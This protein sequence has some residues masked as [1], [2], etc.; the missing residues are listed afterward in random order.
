MKTY[1]AVYLG[2]M[3]VAMLLNP[4]LIRLARRF[5]WFHSSDFSG[6]NSAYSP[7]S[8]VGPVPRLGGLVLVISMLLLVIPAFLYAVMRKNLIGIALQRLTDKQAIGFMTASLGV[9]LIGLAS[10]LFS[11]SW[12]WKR[13]G[14]LAAAVLVC[15][16]GTVI[17]NFHLG[18]WNAVDLNWLRWPVT[19]LWIIGVTVGVHL[20]DGL[21]GLAAGISGI[22]C[23][24]IAAVTIAYSDFVV[25]VIAVSMVGGL[26]GFLFKNFY[27]AKIQL[28]DS[29]RMFVGFTIATSTVMCYEKTRTFLGLV[30]P[31]LA[32]GIPI[33]N[34]LIAI[35][36]R[37][38]LERRPAFAA[39]RDH[40]HTKLTELG[41]NQRQVVLFLYAV[42]TLVATVGTTM[43]LQERTSI[44]G[45]IAIGILPFAVFMLSGALKVSEFW[46][47]FRRNY[48]LSKS[49]SHG[50]QILSDVGQRMEQIRSFNQWWELLCQTAEELNFISLTVSLERRDSTPNVLHWTRRDCNVLPEDTLSATL[51]VRQRRAG[52]V[53]HVKLETSSYDTAEV[54]GHRIMLF[55]RLLEEHCIDTLPRALRGQR[56]TDNLELITPLP[57]RAASQPSKMLTK[58]S[59]GKTLAGSMASAQSVVG[60][61]ESAGKR[62]IAV[63]HDFLYVYAGAERVLEQILAVYP[64]ADVFAL[65]DFLP[66]HQRG[67]LKGKIAKT[68]FLQKMPLAR[69]YHRAYLPLMPLAIEQLDVSEYDLVI[70]SSYLAAK[71][72]LTRADQLHICYC[73]TPVRFAWD[74]QKQYL[75]ESGLVSGLKSFIVRILLH[76][77][78][79]WDTHSSNCVNLFLTN[80]N[81]VGRRIQKIYRRQSITVYPPVDVDNFPS[82]GEK[83]DYYLTVSRLVPYKRIDLIVDAFKTELKHRRLIVI[84]DGPEIEKLRGKAGPN[85]TLLGHQPFEHVKEYM[86]RAKAFVFAAEEDFGIV[87]LEAQACG[88]PVIAYARGGVTESIVDGRTGVFF[89]KQTVASLVAAIREFEANDV[90][91]NSPTIRA[92]AERFSNARFRQRFEKI[93]EDTWMVFSSGKLTPGNEVALVEPASAI[94]PVIPVPPVV[95]TARTEIPVTPSIPSGS[96]T[97][98]LE[99][100]PLLQLIEQE[101]SSDSATQSN[102]SDAS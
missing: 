25:A 34:A 24:V 85:V 1:Y 39:G 81:Y 12:K 33:I 70:S 48:A 11:I 56:T 67:F 88:T 66:N 94:A 16:T 44:I 27:P 89:Q 10:D 98:H 46:N 2:T 64:D 17:S 60:P 9:F 15:A 22:T 75:T 20:I 52:V 51:P 80:S 62:K 19:V 86:Q 97:R 58:R 38:I 49:A 59:G 87:P 95:S 61:V 8:N 3:L 35:A 74:L 55:A 26:T 93:V 102:G 72:V 90:G 18:P 73:H 29:G 68:S 28:G 83:E 36:R 79:N 4:L 76:Y 84:G 54:A 42:S 69:K 91:W 71:G 96:D 40:I 65:F 82:L 23:V 50:K 92:N 30:V 47:A 43:F 41:Y 31:A 63:V 21:D 32:L 101:Q 14:V 100:N 45:Y 78:R 5:R 13:L 37:I 7:E 53:T 77:V 57:K 6:S 99:S